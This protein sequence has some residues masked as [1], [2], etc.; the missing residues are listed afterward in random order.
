MCALFFV[1]DRDLRRDIM[2]GQYRV[3]GQN[4]ALQHTVYRDFFQRKL[5]RIA[6][7][8]CVME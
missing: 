8:Y 7:C 2:L 4:T 3:I 1:R 5:F 6:G